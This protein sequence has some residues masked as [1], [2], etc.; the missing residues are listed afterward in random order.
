MNPVIL[1]HSP[2]YD[3]PIIEREALDGSQWPASPS[4]GCPR[5]RNGHS[6]IPV[7]GEFLIHRLDEA[8]GSLR[9]RPSLWRAVRVVLI[10]EV[11]PDVET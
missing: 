3:V 8:Y 11:D 4:P 9:Q 2:T 10:A 1:R 7:R 5:D 6:S